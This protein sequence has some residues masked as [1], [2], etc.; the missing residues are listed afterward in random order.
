[1]LTRKRQKRGSGTRASNF[2]AIPV[3]RDESHEVE[4]LG[5]LANLSCFYFFFTSVKK[6]ARYKAERMGII[7]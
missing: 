3:R 5:A 1:M 6:T 7:V 2:D 4:C